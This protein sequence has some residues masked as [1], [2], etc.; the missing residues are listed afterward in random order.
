MLKVFARLCW[1]VI[2]FPCWAIPQQVNF[3]GLLVNNGGNLVDTTVSMTFRIYTDSTS[4]S[5]L[6]TETRSAVSSINGLFNVRLGQVI[7]LPD[8]IFNQ[9]QLWLGVT[10]GADDEMVPR[11]FL[12]SVPY[13]Y[14]VSSV[15]GAKGGVISGPLST[16]TTLQAE[17][18]RFLD[19]TTQ[20]TASVAGQQYADTNSYDATRAWTSVQVSLKQSNSDTITWDATRTWV[21]SQLG[22][23]QADADT[24]TWDATKA[25]LAP[26]QNDSD[27]SLWDATRTWVNSM[28]YLRGS[29]NSIGT[30]GFVG[31]GNYNSASGS[32]SFVGGGGGASSADANS[33]SGSN[34][35]IGGGRLNFASAFA[36]T[37]G[38]G[39]ANQSIADYSTIGGGFLNTVSGQMSVIGGGNNNQASNWNTTVGGGGN[40]NAT[41]IGATVGGGIV[42][43][44]RGEFAVVGGGGGQTHSDSN[45]ATG[46]QS[47]ISGGRGNYASGTYATISGGS[48]NQATGAFSS[49]VGGGAANIVCG[50][51]ATISGGYANT[52]SYAGCVVGGGQSNW[53]NNNYATIGGGISNT[54]G[55]YAGTIGGGQSNWASGL[56]ATVPGGYNNRAYAAYSFAAGNRAYAGGN[57]TFV[58]SDANDADFI[59]SNSNCFA[60]RST[61][62]VYF[63]TN[64]SETS[65]VNLP[66]GGS[67]WNAVSDSTKKQNIRLVDTKDML[68]KVLTLPIKKWSYKSQDPSVEHIGP[69]AQDFWSAFHVGDDSLCGDTGTGEAVRKARRA[70]SATSG[71]DTNTACRRQAG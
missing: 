68:E 37:V 19:G 7:P 14:R 29:N 10:V 69:M 64:L 1:L 17:G 16:D 12:S 6:W 36:S 22:P 66:S 20:F 70:E 24:T 5:L 32:Y 15:D 51:D 4:G 44:A 49:T 43:H 28:G 23:L 38:G 67:A 33:A 61:G 41:G 18:I 55:G 27:T 48:G 60:V 46:A 71:T 8:G 53:A 57:G 52:A 65:G 59:V 40:N 54:I 25:N 42:N 47:V 9:P 26:L 62:G 3:Q 31:G 50:Q 30:T 56:Y 35:V 21:N 63:F 11:N 13:S 39:N 45:S 58:W 34:S 2:A